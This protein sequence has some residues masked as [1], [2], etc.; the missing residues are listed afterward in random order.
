MTSTTET[1]LK[2][3]W[4]WPGTIALLVLLMF[5]LYAPLFPRIEGALL[6]VTG[7]IVFVEITLAPDGISTIARMQFEKLRDCEY[8]GVTADRAGEPVSMEPV[9]GGAPIS[10]PAGKR[11]SRPWLFGTL[12]LADIRIRWVHRC[13]PF[14][15][16][17]TVGYP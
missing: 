16:T 15:T 11:L 13:N 7:K 17:V 12:D 14:W 9:S 4:S 5:P 2:V 1:I 6:P 3:T 8:L 10:L